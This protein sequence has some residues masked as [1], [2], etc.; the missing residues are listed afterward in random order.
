GRRLCPPA[1]A[2]RFACAYHPGARPDGAGTLSRA[3][4]WCAAR[5]RG[6]AR[7]G[8]SEPMRCGI[9]LAGQK[10]VT[11]RRLLSIKQRGGIAMGQHRLAIAVSVA[12]AAAF[13]QG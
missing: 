2:G 12:V 8:A 1:R 11:Y 7:L 13:S 4:W 6:A 10:G 9:A 5:V 3:L